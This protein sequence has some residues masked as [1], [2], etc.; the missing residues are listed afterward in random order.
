MVWGKKLHETEVGRPIIDQLRFRLLQTP[1]SL[2][3]IAL[4]LEMS[5]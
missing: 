5:L 2:H 3:Y 1:L 4:T